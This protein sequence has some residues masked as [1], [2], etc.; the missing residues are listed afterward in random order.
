MAQATAA[1]GHPVAS[2]ARIPVQPPARPRPGRPPGTRRRAP[3][4]AREG[5]DR[6]P[7]PSVRPGPRGCSRPGGTSKGGRSRRSG[8]ATGPA[9]TTSRTSSSPS[10]LE[11]GAPRRA[12]SGRAGRRW[13]SVFVFEARGDRPKPLRPGGP[14][15]RVCGSGGP[16]IDTHRHRAQSGRGRRRAPPHQATRPRFCRRSHTAWAAGEDL[17]HV[18]GDRGASRVAT[19]SATVKQLIDLL[20]QLGGSGARRRPRQPRRAGPPTLSSAGWSPPRRWSAPDGH[21]VGAHRHTHDAESA[22]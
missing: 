15:A 3:G 2:A 17:T 13:L 20:H 10:A 14:T 18:I 19:S 5:P 9:S 6:V 12:R 1:A 22:P 11:T 21:C 7:G 8:G 16:M 4:E